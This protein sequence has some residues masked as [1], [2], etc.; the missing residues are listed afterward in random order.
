MKEFIYSYVLTVPAASPLPGTFSS[1]R[2][3]R[4]YE[5][6]NAPTLHFRHCFRKQRESLLEV[7][8]FGVHNFLRLPRGL[9]DKLVTAVLLGCSLYLVS[10]DSN[11]LHDVTFA[12]LHLM[13][14]LAF[15][16]LVLP[17][18]PIQYHEMS[19]CGIAMIVGV[20]RETFPLIAVPAEDTLCVDL[21]S[22]AVL[23]DAVP[24]VCLP[25]PLRSFSACLEGKCFAKQPV[26]L[27]LAREMRFDLYLLD[28]K[29]AFLELRVA[30]LRATL[31]LLRRSLACYRFEP[32]RSAGFDRQKFVREAA[33]DFEGCQDFFV[34]LCDTQHF[35]DY[36][37]NAFKLLTDKKQ[38]V[39]P[40][41][42]RFTEAL[43]RCHGI[44]HAKPLNRTNPDLQ[45]DDSFQFCTS[46]VDLLLESDL[47]SL[48]E[49]APLLDCS[50]RKEYILYRAVVDHRPPARPEDPSPCSLFK[51]S[52]DPHKLLNLAEDAPL[53]VA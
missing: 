9:V 44:F 38:P 11:L 39:D 41:A 8:L 1:Y 30:Y 42:R 49:V 28:T 45:I 4:L 31:Q 7:P 18:L 34:R 43:L 19:A 22:G 2:R 13:D 17:S 48:L 51:P 29:Q 6:K 52:V 32:D 24:R 27:E 20:G 21:D 5:G 25:G 47:Q 10:D 46:H 37:A 33:R 50:L 53:L 23:L 40:K 15:N 26:Q 36:S 16:L 12:L 14:P 35:M 3:V